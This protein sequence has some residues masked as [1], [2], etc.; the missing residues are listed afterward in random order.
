MCCCRRSRERRATGAERVI[1]ARNAFI[2][3]SI[4]RDVVRVRHRARAR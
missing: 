1:D 2:M 3:T 4:M